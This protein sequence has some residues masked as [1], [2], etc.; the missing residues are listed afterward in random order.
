MQYIMPA[1]FV[2][3]GLVNLNLVRMAFETGKIQSRFFDYDKEESP[4]KFYICI[5]FQVLL[6][7]VCVLAAVYKV[8]YGV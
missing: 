1:V 8:S 2:L 5:G 6:S 4:T 7:L 3:L